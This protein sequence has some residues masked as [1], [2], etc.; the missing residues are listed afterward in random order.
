MAIETNEEPSRERSALGEPGD[1]TNFPSVKLDGT[2][3]LFR[4]VKFVRPNPRGA[5]WFSFIEAGGKVDGRFDLPETDGTCYLAMDIQTAIREKIG[6]GICQAMLVPQSMVDAMEVV[7]LRLPGQYLLA[8][9]GH[10]AAA[11]W[12][13]IRELGASSGS[14][15]LTSRWASAFRASGFSGILYGSR[16]TSISSPTA[17]ALFG[18]FKGRKWVEGSR[19]SGQQAFEKAEIGHLIGPIASSSSVS[20]RIETPPGLES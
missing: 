4:A 19:M 17:V 10:E 5:W 11:N 20:V 3:E 15:R 2:A 6:R 9:T 12:G 16:L 18:Y 14:Y 13:A 1:L 8:D 7:E